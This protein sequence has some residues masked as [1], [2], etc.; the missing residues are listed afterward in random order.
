MVEETKQVPHN[1]E[2]TAVE[3]L[4][5]WESAER[6]KPPWI[7]ESVKYGKHV[8]PPNDQEVPIELTN[9]EVLQRRD[10]PVI[11]GNSSARPLSGRGQDHGA[12][13]TSHSKQ[14]RKDTGSTANI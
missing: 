10:E 9:E 11:G 5:D 4:Q 6:V 1:E 2:H 7:K 3:D 13:E 12:I 8:L 14:N